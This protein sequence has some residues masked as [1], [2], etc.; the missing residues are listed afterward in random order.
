MKLALVGL[1]AILLAGCSQQRNTD[2]NAALEAKVATLEQQL[3]DSKPG[4]GEIM[5]V[6]QQHH[7]KLYYAGTNGNWPLA[8]YELNEI[9]ESLDD[10]IRLYPGKFKE[11]RV[12]LPELIP[13]MTKS[14][15]GQVHEAIQQKNEKS[16]VQ[17]YRA[18][19]T[20]C[21]SCHAAANDPFIR[22]KIPAA[23]M[24]SD[25]EFTP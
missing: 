13:A 19:S 16:F 5:G 8:A 20:S 15:L 18:L 6:I 3:N 12:P 9:Q 7:T 1:A 2:S 25:Q 4:L 17:A 14:S 23:G 11:V 24:F 10:V 22:I 21:S